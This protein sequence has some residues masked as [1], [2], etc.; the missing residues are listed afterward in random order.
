MN[1]HL[2]L[3]LPPSHSH[4]ERLQENI[5][6]LMALHAPADN[7]PGVEIDHDRQI[8]KAFQCQDIGDVGDPCAIRSLHIELPVQC[9]VDNRGWLAAILPRPAL[10]ADLGPDADKSGE[11]RNPVWATGFSLIEQVIVSLAIA[12]D[13]ATVPPCLSD[14]FRLPNVFLRPLA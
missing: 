8:G 1:Q 3:R 7:T 2:S 9:V 5:C 6:C 4:Q 13:L 12:I 11:T 14:E 10:I